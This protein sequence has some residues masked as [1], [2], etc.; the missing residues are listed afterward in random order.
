MYLITLKYLT[1]TDDFDENVG[2]HDNTSI[3][4]V[5][6][7]LCFSW[8]VSRPNKEYSAIQ[9]SYWKKIGYPNAYVRGKI[10]K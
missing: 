10:I 6:G 9:T 8:K 5:N 1:Q 3:N 4:H 2:S 7:L